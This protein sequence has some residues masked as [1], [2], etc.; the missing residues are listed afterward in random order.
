MSGSP[1]FEFVIDTRGLFKERAKPLRRNPRGNR[2][3][4][5][6]NLVPE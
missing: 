4:S 6:Q 1:N 3:I 2:A 5:D